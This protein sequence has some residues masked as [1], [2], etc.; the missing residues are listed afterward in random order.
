MKPSFVF[1]FFKLTIFTMA[2]A[3]V[4]P[5]KK[6][7]KNRVRMFL[8]Y[9]VWPPIFVAIWVPMV[10]M[11][12]LKALQFQRNQQWDELLDIMHMFIFG[13]FTLYMVCV[14][15][16]TSDNYQKTMEILDGKFRTSNLTTIKDFTPVLIFWVI[17]PVC[18]FLFV[19]GCIFYGE[20]M[21]PLWIPFIDNNKDLSA[22]AFLGIWVYEFLAA[23]YI[24]ITF[25][26]WGPFIIVSTICICKELDYLAGAINWYGSAYFADYF[27]D[28][29]DHLSTEKYTKTRYK[30][31]VLTGP[32]MLYFMSKVVK[33]HMTI[34][35]YDFTN[36][37]VHF[38]NGI[39]FSTMFAL[40][41]SKPP[42]ID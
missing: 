10:P 11:V 38:C 40:R 6:L 14:L 27:Q 5:K 15:H 2:L 3:A 24:C 33:H 21:V 28:Q 31:I 17:I 18:F 37:I 34:R 23:P 1:Y 16:M 41:V 19:G 25:T 13:C 7:L 20:N 35:R 29:E 32:D 30:E 36:F 26:V 9:K 42:V 8:L 39:I 12:V 22:E 4:F